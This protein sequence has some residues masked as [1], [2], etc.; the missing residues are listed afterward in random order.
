MRTVRVGV[1]CGVVGRATANIISQYAGLIE[2][3]SGVS[4]QIAILCR[5][6][7]VRPQDI[8]GGAR[9]VSDGRKL[10][11]APDVDKNRRGHGQDR[12]VSPPG[13]R[14]TGSGQA[15]G[16]RQQEPAGGKGDA[17]FALAASRNLPIGFE[18]AWPPAFRLHG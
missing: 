5:R 13:P 9:L 7:G 8:P 1:V 16:D 14:R 18:A 6:S 2:R 10:V 12:P 15:S 11:R 3:R 4:L 17:V